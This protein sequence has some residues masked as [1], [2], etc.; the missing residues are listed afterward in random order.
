MVV[1]RAPLGLFFGSGYTIIRLGARRAVR[2]LTAR[3]NAN[4]VPVVSFSMPK[5]DNHKLLS[6]PYKTPLFR[7]GQRVE[8][9]VRG[10][11]I[12]V[13][14]SNGRIPWPLGRLPGTSP[15]GLVVFHGLAKAVRTE[16][17]TAICHWWGVTAQTVSSSVSTPHS[18]AVA[19]TRRRK[20]ARRSKTS[21]G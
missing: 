17:A 7:Y 14:L 16:S 1:I 2:P 15:R 9:E 4:C 10:E 3:N 13:G 5:F 20:L 18:R 6:G 12:L 8:C 19:K 11:V 21:D